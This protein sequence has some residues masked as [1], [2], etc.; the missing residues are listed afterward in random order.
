MAVPEVEELAQGAAEEPPGETDSLEV[1]GTPEPVPAAGDTIRAASQT[2]DS[3]EAG[4]APLL[5]GA[6]PEE[7][8]IQAGA[9]GGPSGG[10]LQIRM[11]EAVLGAI[12]LVTALAALAFRRRSLS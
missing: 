5:E 9:G 1:N 11:I 3:Q 7:L 2:A 6:Q 4:S 8:G 12:A 10:N